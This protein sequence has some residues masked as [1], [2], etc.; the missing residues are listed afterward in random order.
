MLENRFEE[1]P[2]PGLTFMDPLASVGAIIRAYRTVLRRF[3]QD[4]RQLFR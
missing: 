3:W 2:R 1:D 4:F